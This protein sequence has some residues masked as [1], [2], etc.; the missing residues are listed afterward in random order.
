M[1]LKSLSVFQHEGRV[2]SE[3]D[4]FESTHG[5]ELVRLGLAVEVKE[6][7]EHEQKPKRVKK[8]KE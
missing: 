1:K 7:D 3:G 8:A 6:G 5:D 2:I 4:V